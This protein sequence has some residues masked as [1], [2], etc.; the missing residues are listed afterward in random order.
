V[1][2]SNRLDRGA[3][4]A[5]ASAVPAALDAVA[6]ARCR[7]VE[8]TGSTRFRDDL[9]AVVAAASIDKDRTT[10]PVRL[11]TEVIRYD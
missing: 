8:P 4:A 9:R 5:P 2:A 6:T 1:T 7:P 11:T 3:G 10:R